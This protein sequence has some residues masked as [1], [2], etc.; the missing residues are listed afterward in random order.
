MRTRLRIIGLVLLALAW[1]PPA[2]A[3]AGIGPLLTAPHSSAPAPS[4]VSLNTDFTS[5]AGGTTVIATGTNLTGATVSIGGYAATVVTNTGTVLTVTSG[6]DTANSTNGESSVSNFS[7]TT[8]GGT[9]SASIWI[10]PSAWSASGG[11]AWSM[12]YSTCSLSS[13]VTDIYDQSGNGNN[14]EPVTGEV[15]GAACHTSGGGS[16]S[17]LAYAQFTAGTGYPLETT[18]NFVPGTGSPEMIVAARQISNVSYPGWG[19][20]MM[21][22]AN[23]YP[24][25][26]TNATQGHLELFQSTLTAIT[27]TEGADFWADGYYS[28]TAGA[29]S[30]NGGTANTG[31]SPSLIASASPVTIGGWIPYPT[32]YNWNGYFYQAFFSATQ[33]SS[34]GRANFAAYFTWKGL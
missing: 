27:I 17:N 31:G 21:G 33:Y 22:S 5:A 25:I 9:A 1:S 24:S 18:T 16:G 23:T 3:I 11:A 7:A 8:S 14:L 10:L 32:S 13:L 19:A 2:L 28:S 26:V 29:L 15:N 20:L 4:I 12:Q 6:V 30:V 34:T